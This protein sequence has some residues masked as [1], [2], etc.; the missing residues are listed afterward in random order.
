MWWPAGVHDRDQAA[1]R[2][3]RRSRRAHGET[4]PRVLRGVQA[5]SPRAVVVAAA[6]VAGS[7]AAAERVQD[8]A[9]T[10]SAG[11]QA[12]ARGA[13]GGGGA[14]AGQGEEEEEVPGEEG[15][16]EGGQ[17]AVGHTADVHH[18]VDAVQHTGA[19]QAVHR[20]G[21]QRR[22]RRGRQRQGV[23]DAGRVGLLL[24]PVL[25][26]QHHQPGVL[27]AVQRHVPQDVRAHTQV[28]VEHPQAAAAAALSRV[29]ATHTGCSGSSARSLRRNDDSR[30]VSLR[31][32][33][34][35]NRCIDSKCSGLGFG[36][37]GMV[38]ERVW[39][40]E[41]PR[42]ICSSFGFGYDTGFKTFSVFVNGF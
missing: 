27:R 38:S 15:R 8:P 11:R 41:N 18:H 40:F 17:D 10:A 36:L 5:R 19:A 28:Q 2:Q 39:G 35:R 23:G 31:V 14:A 21:G 3:L 20:G 1:G 6:V 24:L 16:A 7:A 13:G 26:Q 4:V 34:A 42:K 12:A 29:N 30:G 37:F 22:R 9:A 25:H 33:G 32:P